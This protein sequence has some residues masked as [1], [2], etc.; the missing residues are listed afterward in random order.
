[1]ISSAQV[2]SNKE[3]KKE[4]FLGSASSFQYFNVIETVHTAR[5]YDR[6]IYYF[7]FK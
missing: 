2:K 3:L 4:Y 6:E 5:A 7:S 1:M